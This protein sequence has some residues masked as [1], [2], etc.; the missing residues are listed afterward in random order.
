MVMFREEVDGE[1][2]PAMV[3]SVVS[4]VPCPLSTRPTVPLPSTEMALCIVPYPNEIEITLEDGQ[5]RR[6]QTLWFLDK[7]RCAQRDKM[8]RRIGCFPEVLL[9]DALPLSC[10][11]CTAR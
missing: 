4:T 11:G 5:V 3:L 6:L 9:K 7:I 10:I 1:G 2:W 8:K